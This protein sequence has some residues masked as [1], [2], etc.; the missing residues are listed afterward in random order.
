MSR[1]DISDPDRVHNSETRAPE[2][3]AR[4]EPDSASP[5]AGRGGG[6]D[7]SSAANERKERTAEPAAPLAAER[8]ARHQG[9]GRTYRLR[10]SEMESMTDMG[11]FRTL[12][13]QDLA[14]FVYR[15]DAARMKQ[16]LQNLRG[17][18]LVEEKT[19]FRAHKSARKL[20]T[21]TGEGHRI[22]SKASGL[23]ESQRYYHGFVKPKELD[24]DADLYKVYQKAV[25]EIQEKGGKPLRVRLDFELKESIN[26]AREAAGRMSGEE[27]TR[28]LNA[29][30]RQNGLAIKGTT[31]HLPD[32][33][34]EY[35]T[36]E[37]QIERE[38]L[39]LLSK[40]YREDGI[41]GKVGAGFKIYARSGEAN[42]VRRALG[43]TGLIRE[44][45]S[46]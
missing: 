2:G 35:Q 43:D 22:V 25:Q 12:D 32:I 10:R 26:R 17:Q 20:L 31:I 45:L 40:N 21:L 33:Q 24:H 19:V 1:W 28:L 44:V 23:G 16:D 18:G 34:V 6:S 41:R 39:E 29:I 30:A 36:R 38:N 14:R 5:S 3:E 46:V 11:R 13:V 7:S 4:T 42:R 27:R 8:R 37:G 15:G 9:R